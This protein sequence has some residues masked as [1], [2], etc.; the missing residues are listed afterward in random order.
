VLVV[1]MVAVAVNVLFYFGYYLPRTAPLME[2][3]SSISMSLPEAISK[4]LAQAPLESSSDSP[5][6]KSP[7]GSAPESPP[8]Q[9]EAPLE[10]ASGSAPESP[11][12]VP[13]PESASGSPPELRAHLLSPRL[14]SRRRLWSPL[15]SHLPAHFLSLLRCLLLS[16]RPLSTS[17]INKR[18]GLFTEVRG[19][20]ILGSSVS[21][22]CTTPRYLALL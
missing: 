15:N 20:R 4:S 16:L 19:R 10:S 6:S 13:P 8:Q 12:D 7:S 3:I 21:T 17:S 18:L 1:G 22:A 5:P 14:L 11:S 2:R 9:Q